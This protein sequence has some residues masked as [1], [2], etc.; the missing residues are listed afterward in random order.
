MQLIDG[1]SRLNLRRS[2]PGNC[3]L[4][5]RGCAFWDFIV[6]E[7]DLKSSGY[8]EWIL[9]PVLRHIQLLVPDNYKYCKASLRRNSPHIAWP[10][11]GHAVGRVLEDTDHIGFKTISCHA[12]QPEKIVLLDTRC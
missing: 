8:V 12:G 3:L 5:W 4:I 7:L 6:F 1:Q 9:R 10:F 11:I 2:F